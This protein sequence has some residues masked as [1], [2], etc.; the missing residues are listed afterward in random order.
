M[1]DKLLRNDELDRLARALHT[2][3]PRPRPE[4]R[5]RAITAAL[6]EFDRLHR[7]GAHPAPPDASVGIVV[8]PAVAVGRGRA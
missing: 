1:N 4:A 2:T 3:A 8:G 6:A 5:E 7:G